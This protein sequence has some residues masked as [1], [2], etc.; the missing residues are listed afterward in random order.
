MNQTRHTNIRKTRGFSV[1]LIAAVIAAMG[2]LVACGDGGG[3]SESELGS[4]KLTLHFPA[5]IGAETI[6]KLNGT[7]EKADGTGMPLTL[8]RTADDFSVSN[9]DDKT[10]TTT[11][12]FDSVPAG[13]YLLILRFYR[14]ETVAALSIEGVTVRPGRETN[15]WQGGDGGTYSTRTFMRDEF[16][17]MT[18]AASFILKN[19]DNTIVPL[20]MID[21]LPVSW[22]L[23]KSA[24]KNNGVGMQLEISLQGGPAT[25]LLAVTFN[26][27]DK[28]SLFTTINGYAPIPVYT[29]AFDIG[30]DAALIR[31]EVQAPDRNTTVVYTIRQSP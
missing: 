18:V 29:G 30:T 16:R 6:T 27:E 25:S 2:S 28:L 17:S 19:S 22:E 14:G 26:E 5:F 4:I 20:S 31:V 9:E 3:T 21:P 12:A 11:L 8:D 7:L 13:Q 10:N 23:D 24:V 1:L 15:K